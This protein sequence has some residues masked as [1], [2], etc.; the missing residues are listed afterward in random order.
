MLVSHG[1]IGGRVGEGRGGRVGEG[2]EGGGGEG[3]GTCDRRK[4]CQDIYNFLSTV[5]Y[6]VIFIIAVIV[7]LCCVQNNLRTISH[8]TS[9]KTQ[10]KYII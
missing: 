4:G 9:Y 3:G 1:M 2:R 10:Q 8:Y 5:I 7:Y 6:F